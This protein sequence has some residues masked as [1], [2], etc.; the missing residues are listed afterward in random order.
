MGNST[1]Y[2]Q[3]GLYTSPKRKK[4]HNAS[5]A[6]AVVVVI[7]VVTLA[8]IVLS[9]SSTTVPGVAGSDNST[10]VSNTDPT[11]T[12]ISIVNYS[13]TGFRLQWAIVNQG[14]GTLPLFY[15]TA[16][17][18][19]SMP[20]APFSGAAYSGSDIP[21]GLVI[22]PLVKAITTFTSNTW[23]DIYIQATNSKSVNIGGASIITV[24]L[25]TQSNF[26]P[27]ID[28]LVTPAATAINFTYSA[29]DAAVSIITYWRLHTSPQ[30]SSLAPITS[31]ASGRAISSSV[32][33]LA[34]NT[35]CD[36]M[37]VITDQYANITPIFTRQQ[38]LSS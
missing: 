31:F 26:I 24:V 29:P 27:V 32:A 7:V 17:A 21:L 37:I 20:A 11:I 5:I 4:N 13:T 23:Y 25:P 12:G 36:I 16:K 22:T 34:N 35:W 1:M 14:S 38:T 33:G 9:G 3:N 6:L 28:F 8:Y 15:L 2:Q 19:A 30:Y 18:P 10:T